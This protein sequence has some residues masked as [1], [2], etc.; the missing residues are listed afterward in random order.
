MFDRLKENYKYA[1]ENLNDVRFRLKYVFLPMLI[2]FNVLILLGVLLSLLSSKNLLALIIILLLLS[3]SSVVLY[4]VYTFKVGKK[5]ILIE[6][7]KLEVFFSADLLSSPET[8]YILPKGGEEGVVDLVFS[9]KGLKIGELE[10]SYK[11]FDVMLFTSNFMYQVNLVIMFKR[12]ETGDMEDGDEN[13]VTRFTL[14]LNLNLLSIMHKFD[15][16][17][18]N[19]DVLKF[20]KDH[21]QIAASQILKFGKIQDNYKEISKKQKSKVEEDNKNENKKETN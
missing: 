2:C 1:K 3:L 20:I 10:Y 8:A 6:A 13:G 15:I 9:E 5:E 14:P 4:V 12:N 18:V 21:P 7:E 17:L 19:P 16:D 11:A